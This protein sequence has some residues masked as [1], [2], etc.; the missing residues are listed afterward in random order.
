MKIK[1]NILLLGNKREEQVDITEY[2]I[3]HI[4]MIDA[5]EKYIIKVLSS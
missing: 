1:V 4:E 3:T 2:W 5:I